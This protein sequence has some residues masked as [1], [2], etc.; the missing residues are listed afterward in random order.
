MVTFLDHHTLMCLSCRFCIPF[1]L[2]TCLGLAA[3]ALDLPI[4][5]TEANEGL[6][7]PA[8]AFFLLGKGGGVLMVCGFPSEVCLH[9]Y[10]LQF[11]PERQ[12]SSTASAS[13]SRV[14]LTCTKCVAL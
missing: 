3:L 10:L 1:T 9:G 13:S 11:K 14:R 8:V 4:T 12:P 2:A 6:V 7:P 5:V